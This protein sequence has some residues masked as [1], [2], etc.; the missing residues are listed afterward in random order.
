MTFVDTNVL[1]YAVGDSG[2]ES[3]KEETARRILERTDL[4]FS[5]QVLQEFYIQA[6]KRKKNATGKL[7]LMDTTEARMFIR[8]L[9]EMPVLQMDF[10][11]LEVAWEI[12]DRYGV[13]YWDA[14]IL[15]A[16]HLMGCEEMLTEDLNAGQVYAGVRVVNPFAGLR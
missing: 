9:A 5:V 13:S 15:A 6:T 1:I 11:V 4:A 7:R 2:V 8:L 16:A 10:D 14:A 3:A 12:Q